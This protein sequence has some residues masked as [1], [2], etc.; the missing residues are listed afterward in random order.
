MAVRRGTLRRLK[1]PAARC[2]FR[3]NRHSLVPEFRLMPNERRGHGG[4]FLN[5]VLWALLAG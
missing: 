5:G 3:R 2:C 4:V 1:R